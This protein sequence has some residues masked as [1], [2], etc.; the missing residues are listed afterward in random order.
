[1]TFIYQTSHD[2][3][4]EEVVDMC[5]QIGEVCFDQLRILEIINKVTKKNKSN[6]VQHNMYDFI[7]VDLHQSE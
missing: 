4:N 6:P 7:D 5:L 1:M 2:S 3:T